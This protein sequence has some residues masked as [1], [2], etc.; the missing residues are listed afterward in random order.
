M[1]LLKQNLLA[2]FSVAGFLV[3]A[4]IGAVVFVILS[5]QIEKGAVEALTQ[6]AVG[7]S[8]GHILN[9]I[10]KEDLQTPMTGD[11]YDAFYD[12]MQQNI[13][14]ERTARVKLWSTDGTVIFSNDKAGVGERFPQKPNFLTA[15]GGANSIEIKMADDAEN[16]RE[17]FLGTLM[18]VYT[19]IVFPGS[20]EP[21]GVLEIYQYY[22]PTAAWISSTRG[23]LLRLYAAEHRL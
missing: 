11:R 4:A 21:D 7:A 6:E 17:K 1:T 10:T 14:S 5:I 18:E 23:R 22:A 2:Q 19:P 12:Y 9:A 20:N 3:M 13:V 8:S 16:E 15:L